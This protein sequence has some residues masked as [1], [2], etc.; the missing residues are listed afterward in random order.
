MCV[1]IVREPGIIIPESM[2]ESAC[3]VNP[4]GYGATVINPGEEPDNFR[5]FSKKGN[6]PDE[7]NRILRD[8]PDKKIFLHL[9]FNTKG[10]N[11]LANCHP[12]RLTTKKADGLDTYL[13]HN[14][15][16]SGFGNSVESDTRDFS[17]NFARPILKSMIKGHRDKLQF[18]SSKAT[19]KFM[20]KFANWWFVVYDS[21]GNWYK[22]GTQTSDG[23]HDG[24]WSSNTYS[25]N[26]AHREPEP[27][28][29]P[30]SRVYHQY[31]SYLPPAPAIEHSSVIP[32]KPTVESQPMPLPVPEPPEHT[33]TREEALGEALDCL[34]EYGCSKTSFTEELP[35]ISSIE[36]TIEAGNLSKADDDYYPVPKPLDRVNTLDFV[37][38]LD[39]DDFARL[40]PDELLDL[41][42]EAPQFITVLL[43]DLLEHYTGGKI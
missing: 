5:R 21:Q 31:F 38:N 37:P 10:T 1:I 26:R 29:I 39:Y 42:E 4:D 23:N 20:D 27:D 33:E 6:S 40:S 13:M 7:V 35:A 22:K 2:I 19:R 41:V 36:K 9:R 3:V 12:F 17:I 14:G 11:N 16:L 18:I 32:F 24:W 8:N 30:S 34:F 43:L 15:T 25:F 28:V